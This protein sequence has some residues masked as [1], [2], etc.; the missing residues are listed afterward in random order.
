MLAMYLIMIFCVLGVLAFDYTRAHAVRAGLRTASDAAALAACMQARTVPEYEYVMYDAAGNVTTDPEKAARVEAKIV[1][2]HRDFQGVEAQ[3]LAAAR[4]A[5]RKNLY[6]EKMPVKE[7]AVPAGFAPPGSGSVSSPD[8]TATGSVRYDKPKYTR[9]GEEYYDEYRF[10]GSVGVRTFL[11]A[12]PL[13][14]W[15]A[16][17][18]REAPPGTK[19]QGVI[20]LKA[21]GTAQALAEKD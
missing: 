21:E 7:A 14:K 19:W 11:L 17:M 3:A 5:F 12:G 15:F 18:V 16:G 13:G 1:G 9:D 8:Y 10:E 20:P 4:D 6:G 2:Y